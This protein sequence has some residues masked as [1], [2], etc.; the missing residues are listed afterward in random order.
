MIFG[1]IKKKH[2][3]NQIC[4]NR[5]DRSSKTSGRLSK[6]RDCSADFYTK[7]RSKIS[8][9]PWSRDQVGQ[10]TPGEKC[11]ASHCA[12]ASHWAFASHWVFAS[13]GVLINILYSFINPNISLLPIQTLPVLSDSLYVLGFTKVYMWLEYCCW[14]GHHP[15]ELLMNFTIKVINIKFP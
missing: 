7:S 6:N 14:I 1:V 15:H 12:L 2:V 5:H 8:V 3:F 11:F 13:H 9:D 10:G 4:A